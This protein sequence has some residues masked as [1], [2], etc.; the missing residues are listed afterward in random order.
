[1]TIST[2]K[3]VT[4]HY[5]LRE[6]DEKGTFVEKTGEN[7][8]LVFIYGVG[9]MLPEFERQ[10]KGLKV[11]DNFSFGLSSK[12]AYGEYDK[13]AVIEVSKSI[14]MVD[15]KLNTDLLVVGR[16]IPLQAQN[17][18]IFNAKVLEILDDVVV[19]DLNHPMAGKN[20][21]FTGNI[22]E[23]REATKEELEHGHVHSCG[24]GSC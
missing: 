21:H 2:N 16:M 3:V 11:G 12:D 18:H 13:E 7:S 22:V 20:L 23:I 4:L 6:N 15:G 24:C 14:F 8:P 5:E 1:M 9:Q 17:G 19:M 10:L